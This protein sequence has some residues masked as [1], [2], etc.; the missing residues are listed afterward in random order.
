MTPLQSWLAALPVD[1]AVVGNVALVL[2]AAY[3]A[4]RVVR[5]VVSGLAERTPRHRIAVKMFV[6][7][8]S[9]L[10]YATAAYLVL[11]PLLLVSSTQ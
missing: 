9:F 10:I 3:V 11:G 7:V 6:P 2:V 5:F 4:V 8:A 1:P